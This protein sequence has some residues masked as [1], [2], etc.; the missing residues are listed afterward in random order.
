M[1]KQTRL[2]VPASLAPRKLLPQ[3]PLVLAVVAPRRLPQQLLEEGRVGAVGAASDE[4]L[5][6]AAAAAPPQEL[7]EPAE[8]GARRRV[9]GGPPPAC[10]SRTR[11]SNAADPTTPLPAGRELKYERRPHHRRH[12]TASSS[13][14]PP[15][16]FA[17]V[18]TSVP[19][20]RRAAGGARSPGPRRRHRPAAGVV[21]DRGGGALGDAPRLSQAASSERWPSAASTAS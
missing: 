3:H 20:A 8:E 17:P 15:P 13:S 16:L 1:I 14:P 2:I 10:R 18:A 19:P 11:C 6:R 4:L 5:A 7:A 21:A 12:A 9:G